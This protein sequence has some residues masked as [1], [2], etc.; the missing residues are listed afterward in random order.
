MSTSSTLG[1]DALE[2]FEPYT[3][4]GTWIPIPMQARF[5]R[6]RPMTPADS[7]LHHE[8]A[9]SA[10]TGIHS[11]FRGSTPT[12][13]QVAVAVT[14]AFVEFVVEV[15]KSGRA[16]GIVQA[17]DYDRLDRTAWLGVLTVARY[18]RSGMGMEAIGI[19]LNYLF[20]V[21]NMRQVYISS[22]DFSF[23]TTSRVL[24]RYFQP[25]GVFPADTYLAGAHH[26]RHLA[27]AT[28]DT[29]VRARSGQL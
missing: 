11:P 13:Q 16:I 21:W 1:E 28:H 22:V 3:G 23:A 25:V 8:I 26:D 12:D 7:D 4:L 27:V 10:R 24:G 29:W 2:S 9:A 6:L 19:F 15:S 5:V 17:Y 18:L 20:A 14:D